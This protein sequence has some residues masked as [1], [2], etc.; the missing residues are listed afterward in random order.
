MTSLCFD[1]AFPSCGLWQTHTCSIYAQEAKKKITS[2]N[3]HVQT[4]SRA[5]LPSEKSIHFVEEKKKQN[6]QQPPTLVI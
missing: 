4:T 1:I 2:N 5:P 6:N 3:I